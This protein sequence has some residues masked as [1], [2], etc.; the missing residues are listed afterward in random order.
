LT[1]RRVPWE[2]PAV[3]ALL[4]IVALE[5]F[6][7][8]ARLPAYHLYH[9]SRSGLA[10]GA[11]RAL[12]DLNWPVALVA[13]AIVAI[14]PGRTALRIAAAALCAVVFVP[15]VVSQGDLD[16][17][18]INAVP[19]VGVALAVAASWGRP[20]QGGPRLRGDIARMLAAALI[21]IAAV[22][23]LAADL[24]TS[25]L[26]SDGLWARFGDPKLGVKLHPGHH[27]GMAGALLALSALALS[28]PLPQIERGALRV[29]A[30]FYLGIMLAY[31]LGNELQDFWFEQL[32]KRDVLSFT[33]P[34]V[35][36]P[37]PT[38]A[39]VVVVVVG[40]VFGALFLRGARNPSV[41]DPPRPVG[42]A[43][44]GTVGGLAAVAI[45]AI[46][47][48]AGYGGLPSTG[49]ETPLAQ[50][51]DGTVVF[52][53]GGDLF[54]VGVP[55]QARLFL[56]D[57][58]NPAASRRGGL[59]FQSD[60]EG[61]AEVWLSSGDGFSATRLTDT[62]GSSSEPALSPDEGFVA[63][64]STRNGDADLY[65]LRLRDRRL[66]RLTS[67]SLDDEWPS[68]SPDGRRIV[69]EREGDLFLIGIDGR[70][71]RR[72][73]S[74]PA[75][76]RLPAWSPDGRRIAY[77]SGNDGNEDVYVVALSGGEPQRLTYD[78]ADD[79]A[80]AW[81]PDGRSLAFVS[82]RDGRDQLYVT[83]L[84][85]GGVRRVTNDESDKGRPTWR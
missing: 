49:P 62:D 11:G 35:Q 53:M 23:W 81:S 70:D 1:R 10:G 42:A 9:V 5:I 3:W 14:V 7:T 32:V 66:T 43:F 29:A 57:A 22:P 37:A 41:E 72:L 50:R 48:T 13:I 64:S 85:N 77:S 56:D 83:D 44:Y 4:G 76:D 59:A 63:F 20:F 80:P 75:D 19:A 40:L 16:A 38:V 45:V 26:G 31:G 36:Q 2:V 60:R 33:L 79:A 51:L 39:W 15:G 67:D 55:G 8:Y 24:G 78:N 61:D 84:A 73:T 28:R 71:A 65:V 12:V 25:I 47:A 27:H 17:K 52:P 21:V 30:S 54:Q 69:F 74:G 18:A 68:W 34:P 82:N 46:A 58:A 6:V